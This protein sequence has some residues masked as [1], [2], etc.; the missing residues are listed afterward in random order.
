MGLMTEATIVAWQKQA[1]IEEAT[2]AKAELLKLMSDTAFHLIKVIELER[3]GIRDG[4]GY[5]HGSDAMRGI[6]EEM[7]VL[8]SKWCRP[9]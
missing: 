7:P 2:G 4:D 8:C 6:A 1:G 9:E 3:S 5:W